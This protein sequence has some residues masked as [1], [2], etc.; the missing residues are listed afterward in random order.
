MPYPFNYFASIFD[1]RSSF[2]NRK[3]LSWFQMIFT[4]FFLISI[5][6]VPVALQNAQLKTYPLTTF[7]SDVFDPLSNDVM[8]DIKEHVVIKDHELT[9]NGSTPV[10]KS[11]KGQVIL[12]QA[13][14]ASDSKNLTLSFDR[15]HLVISKEQKEL[16]TI[17]YQA[18]NQKSL[19][20]KKNFTQA[21]SS[22]WFRE[23]RLPVSLFLI[24]FSG[25]LSTVNY[26]ILILGAS[27]FLYLTRKSRLFSLQTFKEC[28]NCILNCLGLPILLSVLISL[29]FHQV[30]T[31]TIMIQNVL[32]VLYLAMVFY[33]THF[34][35]PD[36][37]R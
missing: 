8:N 24:V 28:F 6:L 13:V 4:S 14:K 15:K 36:Y 21:I 2:A 27:F 18:I 9:Y 17:S 33:K 25:F 32:F 20:D 30:F 12:G 35:D 5:T 10:H 37:R 22:D 16:A 19:Q 11:S 31:T 34:R 3:K 29:L 23:N 26:L 7:V 1:F